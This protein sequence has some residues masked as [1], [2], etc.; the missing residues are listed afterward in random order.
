MNIPDEAEPPVRDF[1]DR[2]LRDLLSKPDNLRDL[3]GQVVPDL[4]PNF[5]FPKMR[6]ARREYFLA[7][8]RSREADLLFEI[9]Y[10]LPD[11]EEWALV[12]R[13]LEHQ[14]KADWRTPLI[15]LIYA[16]LYWEWQL[17]QW[18]E[19]K[20]PKP[21][22]LLRPILPVVLHT[23]SRPWGTVKTLREMLVEP[24]VFRAYLPDW[25][26][27]FWELAQH[28]ADELLH[29]NDALLQILVLLRLEE[30]D[31]AEAAQAFREAVQHLEALHDTNYVRWQ[32]L[33]QFVFG[34]ARYRRPRQE[35][36]LWSSLVDEIQVS[37]QR[38]QELKAMQMTIADE[39]RQEG[40]VEGKAEALREVLLDLGGKQFGEPNPD[41]L[42]D[43]QAINDPER[44][45]RMVSLL[46]QVHS[47]SDVL[48]VK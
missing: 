27:V 44:L 11:R 12:C 1:V 23:G 25:R 31:Q 21:D 24:E 36:P 29:A 9:P 37:E 40:K 47:W 30:A 38:K 7:N 6:P 20:K 26:P 45:K 17:R 42:R 16:V 18:E 33:L 3:L 28:S 22:F 35:R 8:W 14:T 4:A 46:L 39:I 15:T 32:D 41:A 34:W 48:A 43:L 2:A 5:D 19:L 13:L 10:H